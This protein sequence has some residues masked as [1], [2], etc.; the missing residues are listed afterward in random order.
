MFEAEE[1][2]AFA[3]EGEENG[4]ICHC[5]EKGGLLFVGEMVVVEGDI[6][7]LLAPLTFGSR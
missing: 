4:E 5:V 3:G 2:E 7:T 1:R 6:D